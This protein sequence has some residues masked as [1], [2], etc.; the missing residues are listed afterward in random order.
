MTLRDFLRLDI[1]TGHPTNFD[2][3]NWPEFLIK[4]NL[5]IAGDIEQDTGYYQG[6]FSLRRGEYFALP[7]DYDDILRYYAH[8]YYLGKI[9]YKDE[10]DMTEEELMAAEE[11]D[12]SSEDVRAD[13]RYEHVFRAALHEACPNLPDEWLE[14]KILGVYPVYNMICIIVQAEDYEST[15]WNVE[16]K[17]IWNEENKLIPLDIF[18]HGYFEDDDEE[19]EED[20]DDEEDADENE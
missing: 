11:Y 20:E 10:E 13:E 5:L 15:L 19:D 18:R 6:A 12:I 4:A 16:G 8:A 2:D 3:E 14:R 1:S 9:D 7:L 17:T